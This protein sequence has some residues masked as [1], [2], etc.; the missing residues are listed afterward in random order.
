MGIS[1]VFARERKTTF[2]Q[3]FSKDNIEGSLIEE[4]LNL[5][6][7]EIKKDERLNKK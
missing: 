7:E 3:V 6:R 2:L 1:I 5:I 4:F